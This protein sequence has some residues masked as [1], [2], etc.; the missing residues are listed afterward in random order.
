[1]AA[2]EAAM[3]DTIHEPNPDE[4]DMDNVDMPQVVGEGEPY[5]SGDEIASHHTIQEQEKPD[6][7]NIQCEEPPVCSGSDKLATPRFE[8]CPRCSYSEETCVEFMDPVRP[9]AV[10]PYCRSPRCSAG[11]A[12]PATPRAFLT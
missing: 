12:H 8:C 9:L 3:E 1:M 11:V 6:C 5:T 10:N 4:V 7:S 2:A